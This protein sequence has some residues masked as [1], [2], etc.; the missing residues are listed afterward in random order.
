MWSIKSDMSCSIIV[1]LII[2]QNSKASKT[3]T[4][5]F[6]NIISNN[7]KLNSCPSINNNKKSICILAQM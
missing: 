2:R 5:T 4:L 3:K 1:K 7:S 6:C